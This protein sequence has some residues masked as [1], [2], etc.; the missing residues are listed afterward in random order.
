VAAFANSV[1]ALAGSVAALAGSVAAFAG[2]V[3]AFAS[4][5][6]AFAAGEVR[7]RG[8]RRLDSSLGLAGAATA[9]SGAVGLARL[10]AAAG[11]GSDARLK[12]R[13]G[14]PTKKAETGIHDLGLAKGRD[15]VLGVPQGYNLAKPVPLIIFLHGALG[16]FKEYDLLCDF[17]AEYGIAVA[18]P[19]SR[20]ASTWDLVLGGFGPDIVFL[21]RVLE[22]IFERVAVDP[23]R[24]ALAGFSDG[25]SYALSVGLTNGDLFSDVFAFS[26]GFVAPP[27]R[28]GKPKIYIAHGTQDT[29]LPVEG[30]R[31]RLVPQLRQWGHEVHYKEFPGGHAIPGDLVRQIFKAFAA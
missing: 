9:A 18:Q 21:D 19:D 24:I 26:P 11:A 28:K 16:R 30:S 3:A 14:K 5:V 15:G 31:D 10:A 8:A 1:A 20:T 13:P 29:I 12:A 23:K 6:T 7:R 25:A 4:S 22:H 17:A 2:S 27:S